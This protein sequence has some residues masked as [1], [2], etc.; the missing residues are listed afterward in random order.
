MFWPG[1]P[2]EHH[3]VEP[4]IQEL[5]IPF[6]DVD[7]NINAA[8]ENQTDQKLLQK[9]E[10]QN[11]Q[12]INV[13]KPTTEKTNAEVDEKS[14]EKINDEN[15]FQNCSDIS[16]LIENR[17]ELFSTSKIELEG[18]HISISIYLGRAKKNL[19]LACSITW[20]QHP[21]LI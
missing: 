14:C 13:I 19:D 18:D 3:I 11:G 6:D 20:N 8:W 4:I 21:F 2:R 9:C 5:E 15:I 17:E 7:G 10:Y 16:E 1:K 12:H